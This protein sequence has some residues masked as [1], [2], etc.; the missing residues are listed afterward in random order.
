MKTRF[1]LLLSFMFL[2]NFANVA[3]AEQSGYLAEMR[4]LTELKKQNKI[5]DKEFDAK[6]VEIKS[7][8]F[9]QPSINTS[10]TQQTPVRLGDTK[11]I[12]ISKLGNP[13]YD[14][15]Y[16]WKYGTSQA[17]YFTSE[18]TVKETVGFGFLMPETSPIHEA[19]EYGKKYIQTGSY[20]EAKQL[21][22]QL[23]KRDPKAS[24]VKYSLGM[25]HSKLGN[26]KL[27]YK[28]FEQAFE[29]GSSEFNG[30]EAVPEA[31]R[32]KIMKRI[33]ADKIKNLLAQE[34]ALKKEE[35]KLMVLSET[36]ALPAANKQNLEDKERQLR[37][38]REQ[39]KLE[40]QQLESQQ[41]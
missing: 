35:A 23:E 31:F 16:Y 15:G 33:R 40:R 26:K 22:E 34:N 4:K 17:I 10:Q 41:K 38:Q 14:G 20:V 39:I 11:Q 2:L 9:N 29:L 1:S 18:G 37:K 3:L 36:Y 27:S 28:Y 30:N 8:F 7:H 6:K 19:V 12:V 32:A 13:G 25:I 24:T 21:F 5:S